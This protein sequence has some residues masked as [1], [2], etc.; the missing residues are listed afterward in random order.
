MWTRDGHNRVIAREA[1]RSLLPASIIYRRDKGAPDSFLVEL[2]DANL[3]KMRAMLLHGC[4][5]RNGLLD[6]IQV[7]AALTSAARAK[8]FGYIRVMQ[9]I[10]AEAWA[11]S[12]MD[13]R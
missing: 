6:T 12:W 3:D 8:G 2:I 5:A 7:D 1:F 4:L 13:R 9:L 11:L 10:D